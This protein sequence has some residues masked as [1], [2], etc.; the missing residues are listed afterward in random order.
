MQKNPHRTGQNHAGPEE[1]SHPKESKA[2]EGTIKVSGKGIGYFETPE[3][4]IVIEGVALNTALSGDMVEVL[5]GPKRGD[6]HTGRVTKIITRAK[7][8]FVGTVQENERGEL[9]VSPT[10]R[11][12]YADIKLSPKD[13]HEL[14]LNDKVLV[15]ISWDDP[16]KEPQGEL[17]KRIGKSG[18]HETEI[19]AAVYDSG[20]VYDFPA[21]VEQEAEHLAKSFAST[22]EEEAKNRRDFREITTFTIDPEDAKDFDDALSIRTLGEGLYEIGVHIADVSF[23]VTPDSILDTEAKTRATSIYLVDRTIPMLPEPLSN[24]IC[25]LVPDAPRFTYSAVFEIDSN[26][27]VQKEWFGR[28]IIHSNKRFT[29]EEAQKIINAKTG[30]YYDELNT[31]NTLAKKMRAARI[32]RGSVL[33]EKDEVKIVLDENK[34]PVG[35]KVKP[36]LETNQMIEE[37]MLLANR[38]VAHFIGKNN[39]GFVYRIHDLPDAE[40]IEQL[41]IFIKGLGYSLPHKQGRVTAKDINALFKQIKG[42]P[43]EMLIQQAALRSMAKA[44]Y[45]TRNIGHFGLGF[46]FYTHFTSPIRRYPD[47]LVHRLLEHYLKGGELHASELSGFQTMSVYSSEREQDAARAERASIRFKQ[48]EYMALFVGKEFDAII[49][50]ITEWGIYAEETTSKTEGMVPLRTLKDDFYEF[51]QKSYSMV[52]KRNKKKFRLGDSVR[53]KVS[54]V[55]V[56]ARQLDFTLVQ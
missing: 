24:N 28:T 5:P 2:L 30:L 14:E 27:Q 34:R 54:R 49:S 11:R 39:K 13:A 22:V 19:A 9:Y 44:I 4:D 32:E 43:E 18:E 29:Y 8:E 20:F 42:T 53:V 48:L 41:S 17:L 23:F 52:G 38:S 55:D 46:E 10:D 37:W 33:F 3:Y 25:S 56:A 40:K 16:N 12:V 51:D 47:V 45:S 36:I 6:V 26:G 21:E 35:V 7:E 50:G 31:M 15:R 1:K